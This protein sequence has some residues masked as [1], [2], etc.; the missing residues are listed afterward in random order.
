MSPDTSRP[1]TG[2]ALGGSGEPLAPPAAADAA[3]ELNAGTGGGS[4]GSGGGPAGLLLLP[5]LLAAALAAAAATASDSV[6][7][8]QSI[9]PV[10]GSHIDSKVLMTTGLFLMSQTMI[11]SQGSKP[12]SST[13][14]F[15]SIGIEE[16][17]SS[18]SSGLANDPPERQEA[19]NVTVD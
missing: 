15:R 3:A 13:V 11:P 14:S 16:C 8:V 18:S 2:T 1:A 9:Q 7:P 6:R 5:P 12:I 19:R 4:G 10:P 17:G